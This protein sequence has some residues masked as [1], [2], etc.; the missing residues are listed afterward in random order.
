MSTIASIDGT[1]FTDLGGGQFQ[2]TDVNLPSG[3]APCSS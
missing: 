3:A 1:T 2:W